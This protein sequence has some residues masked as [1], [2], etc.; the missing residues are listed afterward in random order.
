MSELPPT[1][2]HETDLPSPPHRSSRMGVILAVVAIITSVGSLLLVR[3]WEPAR[4]EAAAATQPSDKLAPGLQF[5][6]SA[7]Q[8][9]GLYRLTGDTTVLQQ[10]RRAAEHPADRLRAIIITAAVQGVEPALQRLDAFDPA[11]DDALGD[12]ARALRII[13]TG[14]PEAVDDPSERERLIERHEWFAE[15]ALTQHLPAD[16]PRREAVLRPA[17]RTAVA[18]M[19]A[20]LGA[21]GGVL[22]GLVLLVIGII[23]WAEGKLRLAYH[24]DD[25]GG[26]GPF[27]EA[28]AIYIAW[29][30][31]LNLVGARLI[32][33]T[34]M[35]FFW[36]I[37]AALA[38]VACLWPLVRGLS[39]H[40]LRIGLG[41][42]SGR[43]VFR[44]VGAGVVGYVAGLPVVAVGFVITLILT[45]ITG[46]QPTH[47]ITENISMD[48][49]S[50]IALF[51]LAAIY[52]PLAEET[53]FRGA[54]HQGLRW[55][56][57]PLASGVVISFIFAVIHPQG[58]VAVPVLGSIAL[59]LSVQREWRGSLIA[60]VVSHAINNGMLVL[61]LVML[62]G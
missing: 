38:P 51:A 11:E 7:R 2:P 25:A 12:D 16:D 34:G 40:Q 13:Y 48:L 18:S 42:H 54:F 58:W 44:E 17:Q 26:G 60:P 36:A 41:W 30:I 52:A 5:E 1:I 37:L 22:V 33:V 8:A 6:L 46:I 24:P 21:A 49:A 20:V 9:L 57:G 19:A 31:G 55:R 27:L 10:M 15:L 3:Q 35:P 14:G 43:G 47:P 4:T 53:M 23:F 59:V 62:L 45:R 61:L 32:G 29:F 56:L 50:V 39:F 28:F